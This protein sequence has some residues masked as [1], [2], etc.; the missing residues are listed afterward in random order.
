[1]TG[2]AD[3]VPLDPAEAQVDPIAVDFAAARAS[4]EDPPT[5][6]MAAAVA[7]G[8][9]IAPPATPTVAAAPPPAVAPSPGLQAPPPTAP[10]AATDQ[11]PPQPPRPEGTSARWGLFVVIGVVAVAVIVLALLL[12]VFS[13]SS[14]DNDKSA[15]YKQQLSTVMAPV[16]SAN[17]KL[18]SALGAL[19]GTNPTLAERRAKAAQD[20]TLTAR[21]ALQSLSVPSGSQQL[22]TN[23]RG[24]LTRED[25]YLGAVASALSNP[26]SASAAQSQT[27][28]GNL[29]DAL[30]AI[31]PAQQD[32]AQSVTGADTLTTWAPQAVANKA[33]QA[34][35]KR[36][37]ARRRAAHRDQSSSQSNVAPAPAPSLAGGSDC[38]GGLH[39]GP[40]TSCPF[41]ANVRDAYNEAPGSR[42]TVRVFSPVTDQ[43]YTMTCTPAGAGV[44]CSGGNNASVA[45]SY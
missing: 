38:G 9:T 3:D 7:A 22:A 23:A 45:W 24:T 5:Q 1:M 21:G 16:I 37:A 33:R 41:A 6:P 36:A 30:N 39:A 14:S 42:A 19:H 34:A 43:T 13:S 27:L 25:A 4:V 28:A 8:A 29:T 40:N 35:A 44:T 12:F 15:A 31:A 32:W 10:P 11:A 17:E 20:A 18:S 26:A 2:S